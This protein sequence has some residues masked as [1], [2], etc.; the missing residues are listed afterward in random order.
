MFGLALERLEHTTFFQVMTRINILSKSCTP[1]VQTGPK[2][3]EVNINPRP[4]F[5]YSDGI[6]PNDR[7]STL[8]H[9]R[10]EQLLNDCN[11]MSQEGKQQPFRNY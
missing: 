4:S 6:N 2:S 7:L 5:I 3:Y 8:L 11:Q 1:V 10:E 9:E